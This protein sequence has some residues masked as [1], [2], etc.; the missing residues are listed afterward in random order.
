[1]LLSKFNYRCPCTNT[2]RRTFLFLTDLAWKSRVTVPLMM[3]LILTTI[4]VD[5]QI[6]F[7][8]RERTE[9]DS[10]SEDSESDGEETELL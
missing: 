8:V 6:Q 7:R 5:M 10:S 4:G 1:M 3:Y 9:Y 2:F